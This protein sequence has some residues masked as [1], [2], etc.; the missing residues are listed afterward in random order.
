MFPNSEILV[1]D[2]DCVGKILLKKNPDAVRS[3][4]HVAGVNVIYCRMTHVSVLR[5]LLRHAC[6]HTCQSR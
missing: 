5:I 2:V 1:R 4:K 3:L 6:Q